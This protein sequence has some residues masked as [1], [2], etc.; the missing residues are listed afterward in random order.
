MIIAQPAVLRAAAWLGYHIGVLNS[1][2]QR[3]VLFESMP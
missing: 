1:P 2:P 3:L